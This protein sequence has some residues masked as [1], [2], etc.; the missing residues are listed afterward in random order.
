MSAVLADEIVAD[1]FMRSAAEASVAI[2]FSVAHKMSIGIKA[3]FKCTL[4]KSPASSIKAKTP[5]PQGFD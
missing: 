4:G 3:T 1:F 2:A 5:K